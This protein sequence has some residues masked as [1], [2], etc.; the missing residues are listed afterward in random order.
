MQFKLKYID[1]ESPVLQR[2][3]EPDKVRRSL[4][5]I[6]HNQVSQPCEPTTILDRLFSLK[7]KLLPG[8]INHRLGLLHI[9][10][11]VEKEGRRYMN[12]TVFFVRDAVTLLDVL[13]V[14]AACTN[15]VLY[16]HLQAELVQ[17]RPEHLRRLLS[18]HTI[19][20]AAGEHA[21]AAPRPSSPRTT[22][23]LLRTCLAHPHV[24]RGEW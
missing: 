14:R 13:V 20:G 4:P 22:A 10:R 18:R 3:L 2:T 16:S 5:G 24:L 21:D 11:L 12:V 1:K 17:A 8:S 7:E 6:A 19:E 9:I 23:P 15:F